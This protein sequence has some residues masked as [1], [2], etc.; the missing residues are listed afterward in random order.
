LIFTLCLSS[1]RMVAYNRARSLA[2]AE[3]ER[4]SAA[5]AAEARSRNLIVELSGQLPLAQDLSSLAG[6][7]FSHVTD[8]LPIHQTSLYVCDE[9]A[10]ESKLLLAGSYG[11]KMIPAEVLFG[12]G[13][14]G[15]CAVE[16][17]MLYFSNP[18]SDFWQIS[19][20][21]GKSAAHSLL[22]CPLLQQEQIIGIVEFAS[23]EPLHDT[24]LAAV[25]RLVQVLSLHLLILRRNL[26]MAALV[27]QISAR[28]PDPETATGISAVGA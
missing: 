19:S 23:L 9:A 15:Q 26:A 17:K 12:E 11:A 18:P 2:L 27:K 16:K 28:Q 14:L 5:L 4:V 13:L 20:G 8:F 7:F 21:L 1:L 3:N 10:P 22:L 24:D 6:I 25:N